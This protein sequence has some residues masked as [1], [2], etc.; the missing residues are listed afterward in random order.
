MMDF[1]TLYW[2]WMANWEFLKQQLIFNEW[3]HPLTS[4]KITRQMMK[5]SAEKHLRSPA[6][7]GSQHNSKTRSV[8]KPFYAFSTQSCMICLYGMFEWYVCVYISI[9]AAA[10]SLYLHIW[11]FFTCYS[12]RGRKFPCFVVIIYLNLNSLYKLTDVLSSPNFWLWRK[13]NDLRSM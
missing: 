6:L 9:H 4:Q 12:S 8:A 7:L 13:E 2:P 5:H 1:I 10:S 3:P 11:V